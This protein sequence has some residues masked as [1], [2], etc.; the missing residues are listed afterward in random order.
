MFGLDLMVA[1]LV[2]LA[3]TDVQCRQKIVPKINVIPK[4]ST[5]Q[6]DFTKSRAQ[7]DGFDIDTISPYGPEHKT[8][9]GGLMSGE[10]QIEQ[11]VKFVHEVYEQIG[12]GCVHLKEVNVGIR[13][14]PTIFVANEYKKGTCKHKEILLHEKKHVRVDQLI[15]NKYSKLIGKDLKAAVQNKG[16]KFG[17][18]PVSKIEKVQKEVQDVLEGALIKRRDQMNYERRQRQQAVDSKEEYDRVSAACP[19]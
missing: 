16:V 14:D 12:V 18:Y 2:H 7:L 15:V 17:P 19:D 5:I 9:V 1:G 3:S 11:T 13:M 6:Y 4:Q 10:I 8:H